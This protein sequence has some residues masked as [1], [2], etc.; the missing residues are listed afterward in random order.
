MVFGQMGPG[1]NGPRT[2]GPHGQMGPGQMGPRKNGPRKNE[3]GSWGGGHIGQISFE[4]V[5]GER[6][7]ENH[8]HILCLV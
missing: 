7:D 8:S 5:F 1:T 4:Q 2:N 6:Y 3:A